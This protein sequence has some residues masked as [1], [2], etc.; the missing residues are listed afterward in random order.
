[1]DG[2]HSLAQAKQVKLYTTDYL[3][4]TWGTPTLKAGRELPGYRSMRLVRVHR[5]RNLRQTYG[6]KAL[7]SMSGS[8]TWI[9]LYAWVP[10]P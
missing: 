3:G 8:N 5:A 9:E 2:E 6:T 1:M 7:C 10:S 4:M